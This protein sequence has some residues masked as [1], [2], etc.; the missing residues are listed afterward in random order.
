MQ[1][2]NLHEMSGPIFRE[3]KKNISKS[4]LLKIL[5]SMQS[6]RFASL[7]DLLNSKK[8]CCFCLFLMFFLTKKYRYFYL[9]LHENVC[10]EYSLKVP[11]FVEK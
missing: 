11:L 5:P 6:V 3:N 1:I 2:D 7:M 4:R 9:Y 8:G 10:G